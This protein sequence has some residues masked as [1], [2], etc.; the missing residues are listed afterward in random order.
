MKNTK[1]LLLLFVSLAILSCKKDPV[2]ITPT[3]IPEGISYSPE[4]P[5]ADKELTIHFK[6]GSSSPLYGYSGDVYVHIGVVVEGVWN[7][8]PADWNQNIEKCKMTLVEDNVWKITLS[9]TVRQWFNSGETAIN[10]IGIVIRSS[11][12]KK[13]T[14]DL[15][16]SDTDTKYKGFV[17][18]AVKTGTLP[19]GVKDGINIIDNST[20][21][22]VLYDKD[23]S[24]NR[25]NF[26]HVV[27]DFN[28]WTLSNDEKSQMFRDDAAGSWWITIT[29]LD[30]SKE[31]AFQYYLGTDPNDPIRVTDPY[32][33]KI[34][35]PYND[36]WISTT[37][38]NE[39]LAYPKGAI[40]FA[41]VFRTQPVAYNWEVPNFA[42]HNPEN[43]VIYEMLLRDFT[44]TKD[45]NGALQKLDYLQAL[46]VTAIELMPIQEF[47]G[48]DSW[49]YNPSHF[50]ATDK[51]YGTDNMYKKFIDEC[52]KRGMAVIIDKVFNHAT[53]THPYAKMY[54]N[55]STNKTASNNPWFNVD[56][57]HQ[58]S[59]FHD[60]DHSFPKTREYFKQVLQY[61]IQEYKIDGYRMDLT[62]GFTQKS[63]TEG[64]YDQSRIDIL[65]EYYDAVK[66][67]KPDAMFILEH[68]VGGTEED[69]LANKGMYLWRNV[70]NAY[71]QAAMGHQ[72]DSDFSGMNS[73]PR[74]FVG[75]AE[76]HDEE[77]NFYK[78][79]TWGDGAI[80]SD[81]IVR[82][83][84]IPLN[85]AFAILTPGP[86]MLWQFGEIGFDYSI[87]SYGGRTSAK[88]PVWH[89]LNYTL[90][91]EAY[92]K[93]SK[94]INLKKNYP[95]AFTQGNYSLNI[96][97]GD[98]SA[99]R[100]IGLT[101]ADLNMVMLGNFISSGSI[102]GNPN[103]PK[104]G[105]WYEL[106]SGATLDVTDTNMQIPI[107]A[108]EVKIYTDRKVN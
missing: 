22:L 40:G 105:T 79:K 50:F 12:G 80:K 39:S 82:L 92:D 101:H 58:W 24:G 62:K 19:A 6:A 93:A 65:S 64:S 36:K 108:G 44:S 96:A 9:P 86:K 66:A 43:M 46:G 69:A 14:E 47:D 100:R 29:G 8:V 81:S 89:W 104:P 16:I 91:K 7:F 83:K 37:T 99:G 61:W 20:V 23:K 18:A 35:D 17:P 53:G 59:V 76:S 67:V 88:P 106:L 107:P 3:I 41:S 26:A 98:W 84:R 38:Y 11:D 63:G 74:K 97:Y 48:N 15:F 28:N 21:T 55:A 68:L 31:Y 4:A 32:S 33:K 102:N 57:P 10:K 30:S 85:I 95:N 73:T 51:A 45:I 103:F 34:L 87:D 52:H 60:F 77:R 54:W 78:A 94:I 75:Y 25:K 90:R 13:Q 2:D 72:S 27:G 71:S 70:N 1:F 56:A 49:G 42:M 5:D